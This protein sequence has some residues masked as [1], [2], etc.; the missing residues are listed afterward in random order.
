M[1]KFVKQ[2]YIPPI[3]NKK[4]KNKRATFIMKQNKNGSW[5]VFEKYTNIIIKIFSEKSEAQSYKDK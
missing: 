3:K 5:V 2:L 1:T 4:V